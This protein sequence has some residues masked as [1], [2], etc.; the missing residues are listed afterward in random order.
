MRLKIVP[1]GVDN[2]M[3]SM[4]KVCEIKNEYLSFIL[5]LMIENAVKCEWGLRSA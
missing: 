1:Y 2:F 4:A 3:I 5:N